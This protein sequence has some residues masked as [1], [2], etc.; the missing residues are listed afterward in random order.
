MTGNEDQTVRFFELG[1]EQATLL[2]SYSIHSH[3]VK[4][5]DQ[6]CGG[7]FVSVDNFLIAVCNLNSKQI[8]RTLHNDQFLP[9][10]T[11]FRSA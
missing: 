10:K 3:Q 1:A 11:L 5:V 8:V 7:L 2:H 9:A 4:S 6:N